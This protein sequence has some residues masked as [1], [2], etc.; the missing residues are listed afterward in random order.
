MLPELGKYYY[1]DY[2]DNEN[3]G[4][5]Y[6]GIALCIKKY[7]YDEQGNKLDPILYEFEHPQDGK[8]VLSLFVDKEIIMEAR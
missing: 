8:N 7:E 3:P 1:V 2:V 4:G 6:C 5:S